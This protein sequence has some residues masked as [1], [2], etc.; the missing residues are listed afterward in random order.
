MARRGVDADG[1][2]R[3][4]RKASQD[5]NVRLVELAETLAERHHELDD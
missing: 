1:A 2:F 5:L 4:L 3:I